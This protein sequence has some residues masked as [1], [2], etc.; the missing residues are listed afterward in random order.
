MKILFINN[1]GGGFAEKIEVQPGVT[2]L[3]VFRA[4]TGLDANLS[5][6]TTRVNSKRVSSDYIVNEGD[7]VS[8]TPAKII[9]A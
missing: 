5:K 7:T 1:D 2:V 9:G 3:E 6:Y 8:V 4:Q